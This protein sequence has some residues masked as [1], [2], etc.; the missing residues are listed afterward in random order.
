MIR[1][2]F[3]TIVACGS[4][5]PILS[6]EIKPVAAPELTTVTDW[7]HSKPLTIAGLKDKVVV[8]HFWTNGCINCINNYEH[9]RT[10]TKSYE[11]ATDFQMIGIH[12]PEFE[13][14]KKID[15]IK[16]KAKDNNLTFPIAVDNDSANW[17]AWG[18]KYWPCV[19]LIDKKGMVRHR[20]VGELREQGMK[21]M[22]AAI[23]TLRAEKSEK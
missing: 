19:Y 17:K 18:N 23:E 9:Y 5:T 14:E 12:T 13:S 6:E 15:T 21:T 16:S 10:W 1:F 7:V 3:A 4:M 2:L 22:T 11:K 20:H 8:V